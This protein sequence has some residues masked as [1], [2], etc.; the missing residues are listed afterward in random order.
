VKALILAG[1]LGKRLKPITDNIPKPL[2]E[3]AGK[4]IIVHQIDWLKQHDVKSIILTVGYLK[5]KF[6][7]TLGSGRKYN[8]NICYVVEDEPLGTAG[9]VKNAESLLKHEPYFYVVNG[10]VLTDLDP[11][12]LLEPLK[13]INVVGTIAS[14]PLPSSYGVIQ[15]DNR[16][17]ILSFREKPVL[18]EYWI[19][20][21]V[22]AFKP[23]IFNR[24]PEKGSIEEAFEKMAPEEKLKTVK[25]PEIFWKSIDT[26]KD[27]EEVERILT[28]KSIK[29]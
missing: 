16:G 8:V 2:I 21:G 29:Q 5:E 7:E 19:N 20:A 3:V 13:E 15:S 12:K 17:Y 18:E 26:F 1:G 22:Y 14:V 9:A 27:I 6:I 23:D 4:P 10:D 24:L 11:S 28:Q 25:Y